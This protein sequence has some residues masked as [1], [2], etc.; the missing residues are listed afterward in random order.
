MDAP[1]VYPE[2]GYLA[3]ADIF[4]NEAFISRLFWL[5]LR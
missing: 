3:L 4:G 5:D 1:I 2:H